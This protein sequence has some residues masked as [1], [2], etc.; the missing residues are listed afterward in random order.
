MKI[1]TIIISGLLS[2]GVFIT[3]LHAETCTP[4]DPNQIY[5][6]EASANEACTAI[7]SSCTSNGGT[8]TAACAT[9]SLETTEGI[10]YNISPTISCCIP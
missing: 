8:L 2:Y 6:S 3:S 9:A 7:T 1:V 4:T 10:K 5:Q